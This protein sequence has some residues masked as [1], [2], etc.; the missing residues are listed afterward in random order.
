MALSKPTACLQRFSQAAVLFLVAWASAPASAPPDRLEHYVHWGLFDSLLYASDSAL[1]A[2][3]LTQASTPNQPAPEK[4]RLHLLRGVAYASR[5]DWSRAKEDFAEA[6]CLKT[7]ARLDS[8][9]VPS[10]MVRL[11]DSLRQA[12][13]LQSHACPTLVF[14]ND[15][16]AGGAM[17]HNLNPSDSSKGSSPWRVAGWVLGDLAALSL[18]TGSYAQWQAGE[19]YDR[20]AAAGREGRLDDYL[21]HGRDMRQHYAIR[22]ASAAGLLTFGLTSAYCFWRSTQAAPSRPNHRPNKWSSEW[23]Q[24]SGKGS[25]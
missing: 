9:Y 18:L 6:A 24:D 8:F 10:S 20:Q 13:A 14:S 4:G 5:Q 1:Q 3:S 23:P 7:T 16:G 25:P 15:S 22:N 21:A 11:S 2:L 17:K 19:A 12:V